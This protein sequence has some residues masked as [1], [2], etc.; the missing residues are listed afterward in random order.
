MRRIGMT[1][2]Q[3]PYPEPFYFQTMGWIDAEARP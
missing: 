3:N 1:V 2:E